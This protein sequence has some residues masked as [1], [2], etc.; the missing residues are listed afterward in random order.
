L[1]E[2]GLPPQSEQLVALRFSAVESYFYKRQHEECSAHVVDLLQKMRRIRYVSPR[3]KSQ[4]L[5]PLLRLRQACCHP[6]VAS[7][8]IGTL[9]KNTMSMDEVR[10]TP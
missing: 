1:E 9:Q 4:L 5:H 8:K 6:Q 10:I 2:I 7:K 3:M